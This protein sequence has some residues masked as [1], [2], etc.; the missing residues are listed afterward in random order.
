MFAPNQ[1]P[2]HNPKNTHSGC[3]PSS[4]MSSFTQCSHVFLLLPRPLAPSTT[5]LLQADTQS[6]TLLRSRCPNHLNLP[7]LNH[8]SN[9]VNTFE[10]KWWGFFVIGIW[11]T[12]LRLIF[13][14]HFQLK[15]MEKRL[16][17]Y[18]Q[19]AGKSLVHVSNAA[20]GMPLN[21]LCGVN[22]QLSSHSLIHLRCVGWIEMCW[23]NRDVL[24][25]SGCVGWIKI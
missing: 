15:N 22:S 20:E 8:I 14:L 5:N 12:C 19:L 16:N 2:P 4:F 17:K 13:F 24:G 10:M 9:T 6:S 11:A 23:V 1:V 25:E 7:C 21:C 18:R 3:K